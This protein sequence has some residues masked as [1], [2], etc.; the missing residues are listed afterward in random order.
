MVR[1]LT[2]YVPS[3]Y[4]NELVAPAVCAHIETGPQ[5]VLDVAHGLP[6]ICGETSHLAAPLA[7]HDRRHHFYLAGTE[8][9]HSTSMIL[10]SPNVTTS[11]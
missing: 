4:R 9:R 5:A 6:D 7:G 11:V 10:P 1:G 2:P 8:S 3:P